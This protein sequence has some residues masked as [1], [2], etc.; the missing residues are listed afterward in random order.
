[1]LLLLKKKKLLAAAVAAT[2][3]PDCSCNAVSSLLIFPSGAVPFVNNGPSGKDTRGRKKHRERNVTDTPTD[4]EMTVL[5]LV[6]LKFPSIEQ[7]RTDRRL[8]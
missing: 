3:F 1:M 5:F 8:A 6:C 2:A 7:T 4:F